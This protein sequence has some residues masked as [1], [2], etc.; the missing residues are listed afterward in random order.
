MSNQHLGASH[1][2][3]QKDVGQGVYIYFF[4]SNIVWFCL[5]K[6]KD[7]DRLYEKKKTVHHKSEIH[8]DAIS[9]Y[10]QKKPFLN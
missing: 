1:L 5:L 2:C 4:A 7:L 6:I 9:L 3:S 8:L 10:K